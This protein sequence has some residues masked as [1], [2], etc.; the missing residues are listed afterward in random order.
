MV[1]MVSVAAAMVSVRLTDWLC[2]GL[3]ESVTLKVSAVALAVAVGVPLGIA[4]GKTLRAM[5]FQVGT[6]DPVS[7]AWA[8]LLLAVVCL[9]AA[10]LPARRAMRVEP[11]VA[12]RYE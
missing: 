3:L 5:L 9:V 12:L 6:G 4:G 10:I 2:A 8:I 7:I 1:V 11:M